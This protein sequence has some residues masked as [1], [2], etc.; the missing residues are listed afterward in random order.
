MIWYRARRIALIAGF[1]LAAVSSA[2]A[3]TPDQDTVARQAVGNL[4]AYAAYKSGDYAEARAIW[5]QLAAA[6][7]TTAMINLSNL[8]GQGQGV[9]A[10]A[11]RAL[12]Y[13]R[14]AAEAGDSR[15]QYE[16][17]MAYERGEGVEHDL[18]EASAWFSRAARQGDADAQFAL[19][20]MLA[21][22]YG[23]GP[24]HA[25]PAQRLAALAWLE[26]AAAGGVREAEDYLAVLMD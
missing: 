9:P 22:G 4:E 6:G 7:N 20:V 26:K 2:W 11:E 25:T 24:E 8:Y 13:T 10:D 16:L 18:D 21:T 17:G 3:Q 1:G 5:E 23:K 14:D 15:A 12:A 19:G